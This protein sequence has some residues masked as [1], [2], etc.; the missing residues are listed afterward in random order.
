VKTIGHFHITSLSLLK[1][2]GGQDLNLLA[3]CVPAFL[4]IAQS[5]LQKNI[6]ILSQMKISEESQIV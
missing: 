1:D 4:V 5:L 2:A 3:I 6:C